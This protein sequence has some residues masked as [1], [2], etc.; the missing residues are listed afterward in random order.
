MD[1]V[2]SNNPVTGDRIELHSFTADDAKTVTGWITSKEELIV[3]AGP[4]LD[5]PMRTE[6][7]VEDFF[8]P[9][10][11]PYSVYERRSNRLIGHGQIAGI[12][13]NNRSARLGRIIIGDPASRG[14]GYGKELVK[15]LLKICFEDMR[16]H[17]VE[18]SVF[19]FNANAIRCYTSCGYTAEGTLRD[20]RRVGNH[21]WNLVMMSILEDE[22]A[23]Q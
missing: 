16:L 3:W 1:T 18:L 23:A 21:Y 2:K 5:F 9:D 12:D 22:Y 10:T 14:K 11:R 15:L 8:K 17:R 4:V 6:Q 7:I 19:D 20:Y 13:K